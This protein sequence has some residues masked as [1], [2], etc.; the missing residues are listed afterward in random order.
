MIV[1]II[2]FILNTIQKIQPIPAFMS[3]CQS[4][5]SPP[6]EMQ[7]LAFPDHVTAA[8][9]GGD[10]HHGWPQ[11]WLRPGS[12]RQRLSSCLR[13]STLISWIE[14]ASSSVL[15][16]FSQYTVYIILLYYSL[17]PTLLSS[18]SNCVNCFNCSICPGCS[19]IPT[20]SMASS[21][22]PKYDSLISWVDL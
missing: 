12:H 16:E 19:V 13:S 20:R 3:S 21:S 7:H 4:S 14:V 9:G 2:G 18:C 6:T 1:I 17:R 22:E 15:C 11:I 5:F 10:P 8:G